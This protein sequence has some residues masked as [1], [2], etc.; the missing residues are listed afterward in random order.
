M[1]VRERT[2]RLIARQL[3][4]PAGLPGRVVG[5]VLNRGNAGSITAAVDALSATQPAQL[6]DLGFGGGVS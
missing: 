1:N 2:L 4:H 3:G 5:R 6:A